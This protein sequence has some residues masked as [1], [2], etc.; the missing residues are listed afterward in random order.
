MA[1]HDLQKRLE[2]LGEQ[3]VTDIEAWEKRTRAERSRVLDE[4]THTLEGKLGEAMTKLAEK[5]SKLDA[6]MEK[7][8]RR[9]EERRLRREQRRNR[10]HQPPT[11]AGG[12]VFLI[13]AV[14]CA[15]MGI[16]NPQMWW[17]VFVALGLGLGGA[18]QLA[19]A[20][21]HKRELAEEAAD[22]APVDEPQ[23]TV[24]APHEVDVICDQLLADLAA[25]PETVRAFVSDPQK[26]VASMR[27][28]LKSLDQRRQQ[29]FAEDAKGRLEAATKLRTELQTRHDTATDPETK[30]RMEEALRSMAGQESALKQLVVMSERVDGEYTSLLVHLQE[31]R[32]RVSV[33]KSSHSTVQLEGLKSSVQRLNDEL[34]AIS[35]AMDAVRRGDLT[36]V[37]DVTS[38]GGHEDRARV[39]E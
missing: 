32:T 31:L 33:A 16:V 34:G 14:I 15:V 4:L 30:T 28:T 38:D 8:E 6:K 19:G 26:T 37:S 9:R 11:M 12:I 36:P 24:A 35:E 5:N 25:A 22:E 29:L 1:D 39:R 17:M 27:A 3:L 13:A 7:R 18:G 10:E 23:K 20:A 2:K 21:R